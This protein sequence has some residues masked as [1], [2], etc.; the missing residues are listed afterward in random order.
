MPPEKQGTRPRRGMLIWM[1]T[2]LVIA[3]A[4][5]AVFA[6]KIAAPTSDDDTLQQTLPTQK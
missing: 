2:A 3:L 4:L 1:F 6:S 5:L